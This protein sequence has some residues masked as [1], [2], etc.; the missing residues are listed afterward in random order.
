M[1]LESVIVRQA[2]EAE[3]DRVNTLI[4]DVFM[5]FVAPDYSKEGGDFFRSICRTDE[6][7][8]KIR[9]GTP[10]YIAISEGE[11]VG[12]LWIK[13]RNH[14][15]RYFVDGLYQGVG[16]GKKLFTHYLSEM[17]GNYPEISEITVNSSPFAIGA[18]EKLGFVKTGG[19]MVGNGM[20]YFPMVYEFRVK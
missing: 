13:D 11:I 9:E 3:A 8:E 16:I 2:M 20:R 5:R 19:E 12:V 4:I 18:Y 14:I 17:M 10:I 7:V 6:I 15:S 1:K